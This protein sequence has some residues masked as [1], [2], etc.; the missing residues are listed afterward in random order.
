MA[1]ASGEEVRAAFAIP[2]IHSNKFL[3]TTHQV[4]VRITF[5]EHDG[6][7]DPAHPRVSVMLG[8]QD[9]KSLQE[10]LGAMLSDIERQLLLHQQVGN[11]DNVTGN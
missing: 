3:I 10:L 4:G 5:S 8:Y 1:E 2:A 6:V 7:S 9:A 11:A